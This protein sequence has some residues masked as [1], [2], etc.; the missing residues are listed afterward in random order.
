MAT[1]SA[2][3]SSVASIAP[4]IV[5]APSDRKL[6]L[7]TSELSS[8]RYDRSPLPCLMHVAV[9]VLLE[10]HKIAIITRDKA[11]QAFK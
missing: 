2:G 6:G 8:Y 1:A 7:A 5:L 4:F 9:Q 11:H 10:L 3:L